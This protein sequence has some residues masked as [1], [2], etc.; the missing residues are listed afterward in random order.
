M[1]AGNIPGRTQT[2]PIA[3]YDAVQANNL[4]YAAVLVG[5]LTLFAVGLL[6]LV[7]RLGRRLAT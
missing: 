7:Q 4:D 3:I 5:V 1:V 2:L 6:L